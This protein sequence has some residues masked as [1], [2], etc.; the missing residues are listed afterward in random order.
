MPDEQPLTLI[1]GG[2]RVDPVRPA[3]AVFTIKDVAVASGVPQPVVAQLVPRVWTDAGWMYTAE[4]MRHAVRIGDSIRDGT[5][6]P[7]GE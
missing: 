4:Q 6:L 2:R 5:Y 7:P 1:S 3:G